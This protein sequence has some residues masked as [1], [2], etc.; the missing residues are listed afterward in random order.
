MKAEVFSEEGEEIIGYTRTL[1][2]LPTLAL[3][4]KKEQSSLKVALIE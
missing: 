3:K 1:L 4:V 2:D